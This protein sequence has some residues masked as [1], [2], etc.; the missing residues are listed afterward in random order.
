MDRGSSA[1]VA[2][3][4]RIWRLTVAKKGKCTPLWAGLGG[5]RGLQRHKPEQ[6]GASV[7]RGLNL[8]KSNPHSVHSSMAGAVKP[9]SP[10][11]TR[12]PHFAQ[13][14]SSGSIAVPQAAHAC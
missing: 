9:H 8:D 11:A 6:K 10:H 13:K 2:E 14:R 3:A 4:I 1:A 7:V 12:A 5:E